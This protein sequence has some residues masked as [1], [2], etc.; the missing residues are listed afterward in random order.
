MP[1]TS[2]RCGLATAVERF[3]ELLAQLPMQEVE[4]EVGGDIGEL[5]HAFDDFAQRRRAAEVAD[6]QGGHHA[7]AQLAQARFRSPRCSA[8]R[9][10]ENRSSVGR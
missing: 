6:D 10:Q 4:R 3:A 2:S 9:W 7:L 8:R 5:G 1:M